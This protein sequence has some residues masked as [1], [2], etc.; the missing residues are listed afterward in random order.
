MSWIDLFSLGISLVGCTWA[1]CDFLQ[2]FLEVQASCTRW[3]SHK[4]IL[5]PLLPPEK[6][7]NRLTPADVQKAISPDF[8]DSQKKINAHP[9]SSFLQVLFDDSTIN[10]FQEKHSGWQQVMLFTFSNN[11]S[12]NCWKTW[13]RAWMPYRSWVTAKVSWD[14]FLLTSLDSN[15]IPNGQR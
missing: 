10:K 3:R 12:T 14:V 9:K 5:M 6:E 15:Y 11:I 7:A 4:W 13:E 8:K 2:L 1:N